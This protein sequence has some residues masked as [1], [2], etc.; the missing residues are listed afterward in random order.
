MI[1][2]RLSGD[3]L[4]PTA[5]H[6]LWLI[7][8][9]RLSL[10][11]LPESRLSLFNF[12]S[13]LISVSPPNE[14]PRE[15]LA[16]QSTLTNHEPLLLTPTPSELPSSSIPDPTSNLELDFNQAPPNCFA[17]R[18]DPNVKFGHQSRVSNHDR[19]VELE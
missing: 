8:L 18:F 2:Q 9:I 19:Q 7:L 12:T 17:C 6:A 16:T 14:S 4:S 5:K 11:E 13:P 3:R 10:P 1:V 15:I